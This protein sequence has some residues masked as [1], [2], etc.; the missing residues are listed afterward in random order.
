MLDEAISENKYG[1]KIKLVV[2]PGAKKTQ[3]GYDTWRDAITIK[4]KSQPKK[5]HANSEIIK[6]FKDMLK[7]EVEISS[8]HTSSKK[9][10]FVP[11]ISREETISKLKE[12]IIND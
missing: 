7:K 10:L 5:G 12:A 3:I 8:G 6:V 2:T 11:N 4:V 1:V 9:V